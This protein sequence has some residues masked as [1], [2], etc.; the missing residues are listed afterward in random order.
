VSVTVETFGPEHL[1]AVRR[2]CERAY[3]GERPTSHGYYEWAFLEAPGHRAFVAMDDDRCVAVLRAF[4]RRYLLAGEEV[5]C[6]ETF[7]WYADPDVRRRAVG[8]AVIR[9]AMSSGAPLVNVGGTAATHALL[10]RL[11][12]RTIG[13]AALYVLPLSDAGGSSRRV[14][15]LGPAAPPARAALGTAGRLWFSPRRRRP[16]AGARVLPVAAPGDEVAALYDA[17]A[18]Y[19]MIP[20]PHLARLRWLV[21]GFPGTGQIVS[22]YFTVHGR[23]RGWAMAR[24]YATGSG[25]EA[26]VLELYAPRPEGD[27]VRWMLS[28]LLARVAPYRPSRVR[29]LATCPVVQ[30]ALSGTRFLRRDDL[31]IHVWMPGRELRP[32]SPHITLNTQDAPFSP[33]PPPEL[34]PG[35]AEAYTGVLRTPVAPIGTWSHAHGGE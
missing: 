11:G 23:L 34:F 27:L 35:S 22:L 24:V 6:L 9:A 25:C 17:S 2:L 31:P 19:D 8:I 32:E 3:P 14:R 4:E 33:H 15:A 16:P 12:W 7:D 29:A 20:L 18:G 30:G 5:S 1:R 10:P 21:S 26:A 13:S 28:E